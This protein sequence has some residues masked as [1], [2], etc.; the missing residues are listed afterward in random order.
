MSE[1]FMAVALGAAAGGPRDARTA[2][3]ISGVQLLCG[4]S[5]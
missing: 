2:R 3:A 5:L 1:D 4:G